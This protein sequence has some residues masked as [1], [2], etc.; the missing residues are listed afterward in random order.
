MSQLEVY[1]KMAAT[2][3]EK[4][5]RRLFP[6]L[7]LHRVAKLWT[8]ANPTT[9]Q[10][11]KL[12]GEGTTL[13]TDVMNVWLK[14]KGTLPAREKKRDIK[15]IK[16]FSTEYSDIFSSFS[17]YK[18]CPDAVKDVARIYL[19]ALKQLY[20]ETALSDS[21]RCCPLTRNDWEKLE[22][23]TTAVFFGEWLASQKEMRQSI[24]SFSKAPFG[25]PI[26]ESKLDEQDEDGVRFL[27]ILPY[28]PIWRA[29]QYQKPKQKAAEDYSD[30]LTM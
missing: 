21:D 15:W 9:Q 30:C 1:M 24:Y 7:F 25:E 10:I 18:C 14:W 4:L 12:C 2:D 6:L 13:C 20:W 22:N 29:L 5:S 23:A 11:I 19:N 27:D 8:G 26:P 3:K 28:V 17:K 16:F